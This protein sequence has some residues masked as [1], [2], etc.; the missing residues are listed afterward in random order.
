MGGGR[1]DA[2]GKGEEG[3]GGHHRTLRPCTSFVTGH[4]HRI[5]AA[6]LPCAHANGGLILDIDDGVTFDIACH[7]PGKG[8][9][10]KLR[11]SRLALTDDL[12]RGWIHIGLALV[13]FLHEHTTI[14]AAHG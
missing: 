5:D 6:H 12:P 2:V 13:D 3:I 7:T 14:D 11:S 10:G 9:I 1:F 4:H 8:Q